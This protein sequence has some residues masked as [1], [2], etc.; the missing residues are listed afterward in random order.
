MGSTT[1]F[2]KTSPEFSLQT[3]LTVLSLNYDMELLTK[4]SKVVIVLTARL[5]TYITFFIHAFVLM[6]PPPYVINMRIN[7][8]KITDIIAEKQKL[9]SIKLR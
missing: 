4:V 1:Q 8:L 2:S 3:S 5:L 6:C 7:G 9:R